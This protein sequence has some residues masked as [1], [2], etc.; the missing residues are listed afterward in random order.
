MRYLTPAHRPAL[1]PQ[2]E[3]R[4]SFDAVVQIT[5]CGAV[6]RGKLVDNE[7]GTSADLITQDAIS[8]ST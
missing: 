4:E 1:F 3:P 7:E 8:D 6:H 2:Q 5:R